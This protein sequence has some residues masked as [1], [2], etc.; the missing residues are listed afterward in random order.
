MGLLNI[1]VTGLLASQT[2]INTTGHNIANANVQGYSR[3][4]VVLETNAPRFGGGGFVGNGVEVETIRRIT[5]EFI[6]Q[7]LRTDTANFAELDAFATQISQLDSVI[8]GANTGLTAALDSFFSSL[9][10]VADSPT[11]LP[12]RQLVLSEGERLAQRFNVLQSGINA[13]TDNVNG[14]IRSIG[15]EVDQLA[16]SIAKLNGDI[17]AAQGFSTSDQ[18]NDLL[19]RREEALRQLSELVSFSTSEQD[20]NIINVFVGG[21]QPL[22]LGSN[23]NRVVTMDNPLDASRTEL[24]IDVNNN[25]QMV[26]DSFSGGKLGGLLRYRD[27]I[28]DSVQGNVGVLAL[29]VTDMFN[30]QHRAGI[31]LNSQQGIDFFTPI[32]TD[33]LMRDRIKASSNNGF[34]NDR[35][36][37]VSIDNISE[38]AGSNYRLNLGGSGTLN[39]TLVRASDQTV[40]SSGMLSSSFPQTIMTDQ[41]FSIN[42]SSGSF[43]NSDSFLISPS[44]SAAESMALNVQDTASLALGS[45]IIA[46]ASLGNT[47]TGVITQGGIIRVGEIDSQNLPAFATAGQLSP[48]LLIRFTSASTYDVLDNSDPLNPQNL[49]PPLRNQTF[50]PNQS[51]N[52]LP[53]DL[54]ATYISTSAAHVFGAQVGII[55]SGVSNG[56][57]D[58]NPLITSETITVNTVNAA[59]GSTSVTSVNLLAGESAATAAARI[60]T[61]NGVTATANTSATLN[62]VDDGDSGLLRIRFNG[63]TLTDPALGAVPNPLTSDFLAERINQVFAGSGTSASSDGTLLTV[64][65]VNGAD[66]RFEEF[67]SDPNDR[68]E[69]V[70]IN[71]AATNVFVF[72]NQEAVVGGTIDVITDA[73]S[74]IS[75]SGGLFT[76]P[77]PQPLPVYLGYQVSLAG[78]PDVGDTFS[79]GFNDSGAGDNRNALALASLQTADILDNGSL[80]IAQGYSQLVAQVGSQTGAA[81]IDREAVQSLLFQTT[82][83]RDSVAGV[84]LDEEA[85]RL[86]QFQQSY[87]ASAQI[88]TV[89]REIFD[90]LLGAF[91]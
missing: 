63:V 12:A 21:G 19:D 72:N 36:A 11:S 91:R 10:A 4:E 1:G 68:L 35:V 82:A 32:N 50:A 8:A 13:Q 42:L 79:I 57:P 28:L 64:R 16:Q 37:T 23:S 46:G 58:P 17:A 55:G 77:T 80:S 70:N 15:S 22:V 41:G 59:T 60:N 33:A 62:I 30:A 83:R 40:V 24:A 56:Y 26:T 76:N 20:G 48:P 53:Q 2:A 9:Q 74:T 14:Q 27:N 85:A 78:S 65:S 90:T 47:G 43:Q 49:S 73:G 81:N 7:Q 3:Q 44:L 87:T 54:S 75:T 6:T 69:I 88:I 51:N 52:L 31:D 66:L 84:N 18:V 89:A 5:N 38:L 45:P 67:G 34:P 71:G 29:A 25:L 39:Y 61:L 86:I